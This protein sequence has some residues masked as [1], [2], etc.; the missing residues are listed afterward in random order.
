MKILGIAG[1]IRSG[2]YNKMLI[3]AAAR[4]TPPGTSIE[5]FDIG[6]LPLYNADIDND[7][8]RPQEVRALKDAIANADALLFSTPEYNHS[9]PG[10]LQNAI[11]WAS[12][13]AMASPLKDKPV[14]IMGVSMGAIGAARAQQQLKLV[15]HSTLAHVMPHPGV[16]VGNVASK[17]D[18]KGEITD[19]TTREFVRNFV[20]TLAD[21]AARLGSASGKER[22]GAAA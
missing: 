1:S 10:V 7:D 17:F 22:R 21:Y 13:P 20:Q 16:S 9:V 12:R 14:G 4:L 19:D 15:L 2:S 8:A 18:N 5:L 6:A 3:R 11:D